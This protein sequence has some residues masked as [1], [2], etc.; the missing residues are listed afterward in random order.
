MLEDVI[1]EISD[2]RK[3]YGPK[4]VLN[5]VSFQVKRGEIIGYIGPNGAGKSTTVKIMLGIEDDYSGQVNIFGRDISDGDIEYKRKIGYV[6]EIAEV[7]DN[8]TGQEYLTFVGELYGLDSGFASDKAKSL[9]ELF[10][11]GEVYHSRIASYSKGM[12]QKLLIIS[13]LLHNPE[14]LFFDEPINGL[15]ANSVMIFKEIMAQLAVQGKTIFY[16]SHI[17][18]VVEKISSR[19]ILL[20]DGRIAADGTFDELKQQNTEGSLEQI[21]NQLTGFSEHKE[22]GAR[23]V[24]VVREM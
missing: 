20:H 17:M 14:L 1:L 8:L 21:F 5:G 9:M 22:L 15:D 19:I 3:N 10:G 12:R 18:D 16:S 11:V 13:S 7:Y 2:L 23:F 24:S 6:P 4:S